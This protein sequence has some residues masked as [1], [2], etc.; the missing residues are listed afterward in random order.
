MNQGGK[1]VKRYFCL[2]GW[3]GKTVSLERISPGGRGRV[4]FMF[5]FSCIFFYIIYEWSMLNTDYHDTAAVCCTY[6]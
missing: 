5:L 1:T 2:S 3:S 4:A 6:N